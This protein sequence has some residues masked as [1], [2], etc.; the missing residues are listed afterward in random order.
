MLFRN[1]REQNKKEHHSSVLFKIGGNTLSWIV[2]LKVYG[3]EE[4]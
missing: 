2:R 3:V 4:K 1:E